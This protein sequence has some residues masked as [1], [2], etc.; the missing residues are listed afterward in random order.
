M[1]K[2]Q[3]QHYRHKEATAVLR[4]ESGAQGTFPKSKRKPPQEYRFDSS[5]A[6]EL[7]W[8]ENPNRSEAEKHIADILAANSID[9][10]ISCTIEKNESAFNIAVLYAQANSDLTM[11]DL[12][13]DTRTSEIFAVYC[14]PYVRLSE[15]GE[16][17]K[18]SE[19]LYEVELRGLDILNSVDMETTHKGG[20]DVPCWMLDLDYDGERFRAGQVFFLHTVA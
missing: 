16:K 13:K 4:P 12:L 20:N 15:S 18:D 11:V 10:A 3:S 6:P 2:K 14:M 1:P 8:D 5:L 17:N 9:D 7:S 19:L